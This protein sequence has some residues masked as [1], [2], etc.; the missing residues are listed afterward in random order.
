LLQGVDVTN[1]STSWSDGLA[2]CALIHSFYPDAFD[3]NTLTA[4]DRRYNLQLAFN[5]A[6]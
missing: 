3:F 6:K 1:Y 4:N 5:T 2:F